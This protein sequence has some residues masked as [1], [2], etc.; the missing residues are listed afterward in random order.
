M[1]KEVIVEKVVEHY[2]DRIVEVIREP[3]LNDLEVFPI[4]SEFTQVVEKSP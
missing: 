3:E 2:V 1:I 4:V